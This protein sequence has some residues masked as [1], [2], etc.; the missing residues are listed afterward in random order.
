MDGS[1]LQSCAE[2][3]KGASETLLIPLACRARG[4]RERVLK[5]FS[6]PAAEQLVKALGVDLERY[7]VSREML[8]GVIHRGDFFDRRCLDFLSRCPSGTVLNLGA[9]LN[10]SYER[11]RQAFPDGDWRWIDTDLAPVIELREGLFEDDERR[12]TAV[13]DASSLE[14]VTNRLNSINGPL[15]VVSEAVLIYV[16]PH[17]VADVFKAVAHRGDAEFLFDWVSPVMMRNSRN[18]PAMKKLRDDS[19]VFTSSLKRA[20][21]IGAYDPRWRI[22][23][24]SSAPMTKS[25]LGGAIAGFFFSFFTL[26]RR[27]YGCAHAYLV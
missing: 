21:D 2:A 18:H 14:A 23:A 4:S 13:L 19:V 26:G 6:D 7:A 11:I 8:L 5:R 12:S 10:T 24:E 9:G 15:L 20:S 16:Q 3:L 22:K 27:V 1:D 25:S 17:A